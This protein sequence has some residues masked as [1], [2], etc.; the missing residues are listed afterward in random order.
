MS[1][2]RRIADIPPARLAALNA[3]AEAGNLTECLAVDFAALME[4]T[5][6]DPGADAI[7]GMRAA[8]SLGISKRMALAGRVVLGLPEGDRERLASH[9]SDTV[10]GWACFALGQMP[11]QPFATRLDMLRPLA[12]DAHFG[13][14]EWAWMALRP[15]IAADPDNAIAALM[16]WIAEPSERLRRFVSEATRPRGV[17]CAHL[18]PLRE[19]P[20]RALPLLEPLRA[21]PARY[22]QDSVGNWLNDAA[23]DRPDW[24]RALCDRWRRESPVHATDYI[25]KRATRSIS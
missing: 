7:A 13:V 4:V 17:W 6:P 20:E 22:V 8:A 2:A 12:D 25:R 19:A 3:G 15:H 5:L 9:P 16:P 18:R 10:R 14:R 23:K 1:G 11:D 21:D 24:V